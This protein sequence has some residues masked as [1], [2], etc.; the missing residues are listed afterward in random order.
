[1]VQAYDGHMNLILGD[2][3]ETIYVVDVNDESGAETVRVSLNQ[4][5]GDVRV[6][7]HQAVMRTSRAVFPSEIANLLTLSRSSSSNP[8]CFQSR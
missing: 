2:V 6:L 4:S 3:E 8:V 1:M 5:A 7:C